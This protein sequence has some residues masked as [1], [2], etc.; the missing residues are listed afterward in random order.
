M[1][2]RARL[3]VSLPGL[4]PDRPGVVEDAGG[5]L[6]RVAGDAAQVAGLLARGLCSQD[7]LALL[8]PAL[9]QELSHLAGPCVVFLP[10]AFSFAVPPGFVAPLG[11]LAAYDG[12]PA[13]GNPGLGPGQ[14]LLG[15]CLPVWHRQAMR[16][17]QGVQPGFAL[18]SV[19]FP[20]VSD[21]FPLVSVALALVSDL[22]PLVSVPLALVSIPLAPVGPPVLRGTRTA[23]RAMLGKL[24]PFR[25]RYLNSRV[26]ARPFP[27]RQA[28]RPQADAASSG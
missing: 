22:L 23:P 6:D 17:R 13:P 9:T 24:H 4:L 18:V 16:P 19:A 1:P 26:D 5:P 11:G 7:G 12:L 2:G 15:A 20:L 10:G 8:L 21:L 28:M 14:R 25:M 27:A 3:G